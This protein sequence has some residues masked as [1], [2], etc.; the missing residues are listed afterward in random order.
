MN[1]NDVAPMVGMVVLFISTAVVLVLRPISKRLGLYL[2]VLAEERRR[3]LSQKPMDRVEAQRI[4]QLLENV[5]QRLAHL[6][7]R[8]EFTDKLL[9]DRSTKTREAKT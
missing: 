3:E 1:P 8:Q 6:E 4:V 7:E 2:E 5:D 9:S